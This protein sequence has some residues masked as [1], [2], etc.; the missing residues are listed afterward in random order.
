MTQGNPDA[1]IFDTHVHLDDEAFAED[2]ESVIDA[3]HE[4]GILAFLNVGYSPERWETSAE[5]RAQ[6]P[7]VAITLGLH[8]QLA[9]RFDVML[10]M[11]LEDA[12][13][14]LKPVALGEIGLDFAPGNP[15]PDIQ[16][17]AF[18][19]QLELAAAVG[20]PVVIHQRAA[21]D[22]LATVI[23]RAAVTT[24]IV[25]HSFDGTPRLT[26]WAIERGAFI[27]IGGLATRRSSEELRRLL[28]AVPTDRLLLETD[29]P[30]LVP[31][32]I[33][34]RRNV[35]A[36]L[37]FIAKQLAPLWDVGPEELCRTTTATAI[38]LFGIPLQVA[39]K[40]QQDGEY[41][42]PSC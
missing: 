32:G 11:R 23:D 9:E 10:V 41:R 36:N 24:P 37:P 42:C 34:G 16:R 21:A 35:P 17:R 5:L 8:P 40:T 33:K 6:H 29:A 15:A 38:A 28:A 31:A 26:D 22:E 14:R 12:V 27:G 19:A 25:L 7:E 18:T 30:Y 1:F 4:A 39:A 20:L 3:A 2:R 13:G